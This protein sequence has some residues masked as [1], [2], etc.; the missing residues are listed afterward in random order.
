MFNRL[1]GPLRKPAISE[2]AIDN[3][4]LFDFHIC[5]VCIA[6]SIPLITKPKLN[7]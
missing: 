5:F 2:M 1:I 6:L 7:Q 4:F 3:R